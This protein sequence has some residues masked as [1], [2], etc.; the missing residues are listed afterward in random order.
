MSLNSRK[1]DTH[2]L[3]AILKLSRSTLVLYEALIASDNIKPA[4]S[5]RF[6]EH[7]NKVMDELEQ[8]SSMMKGGE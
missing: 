1:P 5:A 4:D 6:M 3:A 7:F 8:A 2:L